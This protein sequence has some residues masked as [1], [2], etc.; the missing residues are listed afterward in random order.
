MA[1]YQSSIYHG[2]IFLHFSSNMV[3]IVPL[4]SFHF[5]KLSAE[6]SGGQYLMDVDYRFG[7]THQSRYYHCCRTEHSLLDLKNIHRE[8]CYKHSIIIH[9][10]QNKLMNQ[11]F[12][13][14]FFLNKFNIYIYIYHDLTK[15]L[16]RCYIFYFLYF[17]FWISFRKCDSLIHFTIRFLFFSFFQKKKKKRHWTVIKHLQYC[18]LNNQLSFLHASLCCF[19]G[20]KIFFLFLLLAIYFFSIWKIPNFYT[21]IRNER[22]GLIFPL[23][24]PVKVLF[25]SEYF[26]VFY[27]NKIRWKCLAYADPTKHIVVIPSK[28]ITRLYENRHTIWFQM[29]TFSHTH[30]NINIRCK[31]WIYEYCVAVWAW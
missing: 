10:R 8:W 26:E 24:L 28:I 15:G 2:W 29:Q 17:F 21:Y 13:Q 16:L 12:Q 25:M 5:R 3:F 19:N 31:H 7:V 1:V 11:E 27:L 23:R 6:N 22:Y 9:W 14:F 4:N 30:T 20:S 18:S